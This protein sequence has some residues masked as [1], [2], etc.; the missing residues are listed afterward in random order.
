MPWLRAV[1]AYFAAKRKPS[2]INIEQIKKTGRKRFRIKPEAFS[3]NNN[4]WFPE[5]VNNFV[6]ALHWKGL[7]AYNF[8]QTETRGDGLDG[9]SSGMCPKRRY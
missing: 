2:S 3:Y 6:K 8:G 1:F 9:L 5:G 7:P 4:S